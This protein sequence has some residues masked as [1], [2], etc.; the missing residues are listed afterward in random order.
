MTN[1][2]QSSLGAKG[3]AVEKA[4]Q[5]QPSPQAQ[6]PEGGTVAKRVLWRPGET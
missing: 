2:G 5:G 4:E 6:D 3:T 1:E